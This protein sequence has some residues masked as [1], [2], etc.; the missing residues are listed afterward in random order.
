MKKT[1]IYGAENYIETGR[2]WQV[3]LQKRLIQIKKELMNMAVNDRWLF[4][5]V[6][7]KQVFVYSYN[8]LLYG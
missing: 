8:F 4:E 7:V 1:I 6:T 3:A 5:R 2:K